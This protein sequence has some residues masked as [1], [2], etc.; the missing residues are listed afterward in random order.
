MKFEY[1]IDNL[2]TAKDGIEKLTQS[3]KKFDMI[4]VRYNGCCNSEII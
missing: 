2:N 4:R 3:A 1:V